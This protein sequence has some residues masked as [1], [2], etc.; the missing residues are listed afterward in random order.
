MY[1]RVLLLF[2]LAGC[3]VEEEGPL[4]VEEGD[5]VTIDYVGSTLGDNLVFD[6]SRE[7]VARDE[8]VEK[9]PWFSLRKEYKPLV[10]TVGS[11]ELLPA[12]EH[13]LIGAEVGSERIIVL[14]PDEAYGQ[15]NQSL[16]LTIERIAVVPLVVDIPLAVFEAGAGHSPLVNE[17]VQLKYWPARVLN[18][19]E[20]KVTLENLA[21]NGTVVET[22][23]APARI[24]V[25]STHIRME[26][27]P[28]RDVPY[29]TPL[30]LARVVAEN[31]TTIVLDYNHPLAGKTLVFRVEVKKYNQR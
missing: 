13:G 30:G 20:D 18:V 11:G 2:F 5:L 23:Y 17:T 29:N 3:L 8:R 28:T 9:V 24:T 7:D 6:T 14:S 22:A 15:R 25:N 4:R 27:A 12:L 10:F 21:V 26:L 16:L 31:E 19:T 1:F